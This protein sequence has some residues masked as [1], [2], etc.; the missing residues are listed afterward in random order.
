MQLRPLSLLIVIAIIGSASAAA[1]DSAKTGA[2]VAFN[3]KAYP[4]DVQQ[5][6]QVARD[7]CKKA[8]GGEVTFAP[9]TVRTLDLTGDGRDDYIVDLRNTQC[10][11]REAVFCGSGGCELDILVTLSTGDERVVFE[12]WVRDYEILP[13]HGAR[14]IRFT[15]H[16]GYCG[17]H[18]N[19]S[20]IKIH[21]VTAR[22]FGFAMPD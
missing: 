22:P 21:R 3:P 18:G 6:L 15:L 13:S 8:G 4:S 19:P 2:A 9:D 5:V 1:Q 16:G 14:M 7:E 12:Q 20:C 17:G 10:Q 11:D